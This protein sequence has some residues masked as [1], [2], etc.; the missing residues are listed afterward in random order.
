MSHLQGATRAEWIHFTLALGWGD[1]LLPCVPN[2]PGLRLRE[3]SALGLKTLGK[4]PSLFDGDGAVYGIKGWTVKVVTPEELTRWETDGRYNICARTGRDG[5]HALDV[6]I[7]DAALSA[8]VRAAIMQALGPLPER[9]RPGSTKFL[10]P[11]TLPKEESCKKRIIVTAQGRIELLGAGQQFVAAG[12]HPSGVRYAWSPGL[13]YSIPVLSRTRIDELW[14]QLSTKFAVQPSATTSSDTAQP[15]DG[16]TETLTTISD[17]EWVQLLE[18]LEFLRPHAADNSV[19][20]E[21]GYALLSL[22]P[23]RAVR[24][25]W[26]EFSRYAPNYVEGAPESW[27][28]AHVGQQPRSDYRH[29]FKLARSRAWRPIVSPDLFPVAQEPAPAAPAQTDDLLPPSPARPVMRVLADNLPFLLDKCSELL[30]DRVYVHA[31]RLSCIVPQPTGSHGHRIQQVS[32]EWVRDTLGRLARWEKFSSTQQAWT[33]IN[34]P[35]EIALAYTG[36]GTWPLRPLHGISSTPFL[37]PDGTICEEPGYDDATGIEYIATTPFPRIP[38]RP[39]KSDAQSALDRLFWP[40]REFPF[41]TRG[42]RSA[43]LSH[44]LTAVARTSLDTAPMF[45]YAAPHAGIGKS[46]LS[47]IAARIMLGQAPSA[48]SWPTNPEE[49]RKQVFANM[50]EGQ[51]YIQ[52]DNIPRAAKVDSPQLCA[53]LTSPVWSDRV[54]GAT[55]NISIQ[56]R[57][58]LVGTGNQL[59][60][61]SDLARRAVVIRLEAP[62]RTPDE[63]RTRRFEI[64]DLREYIDGHRTELLVDALTVLQAARLHVWGTRDTAYPPPLASFGQWSRR[65]RNTLIWLGE[66]DPLETQSE[67]TDNEEEVATDAFALLGPRL[68]DKF[69]ALELARLAASTD[70]LHAALREAGCRDPHDSYVVGMFLAANRGITLAGY[71]LM[72]GPYIRGIRRWYFERVEKSND[73][74]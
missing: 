17:A 6:D 50:L 10:V 19:W 46:L 48:R 70:D 67:E 33:P 66:V 22:Q 69:T 51:H 26:R 18:A 14:A 54:L 38:E 42:S 49:L 56:N 16:P 9:C 28:A 59:T 65:V 15:L 64:P 32:A 55:R 20:S 44:L 1:N 3:G 13:P 71:R 41:A 23:S 12:I 30:Q 39:S 43:Y 37:R 73:L 7:D 11:F 52:Y 60:P 57:L 58:L 29:I 31:D 27:W 62:E 53:L 25:V 68:T 24:E 5:L 74:S 21:I 35:Q 45:W 61:S 4:I 34:P 63:I 40:A 47:E 8:E 2:Q 72:R 36:L